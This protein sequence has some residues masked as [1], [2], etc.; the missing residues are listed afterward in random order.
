MPFITGQFTNSATTSTNPFQ[1][2]ERQDVGLTLKVTPQVNEGD[3]IKL[4]L[5][6]E[7]SSV[8]STSETSGPTTR[9]RSIKTSVLVDDGAILVLGGLIEESANDT[10]T[11]IPL[12]GDIPLLGKLFTSE[13]TSKSKQNLMVFLRPSILRD[14]N[15]AAIVTNEKYNYLRQLQQ[16]EKYDDGFGLLDEKPPVMP[17]LPALELRAEQEPEQEPEDDDGPVIYDWEG[18]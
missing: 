13:S 17:E 10:V 5:E 4:D 12:L 18:I 9:K 15:D 3:T 1:T 6:Q 14:F 7:T 16:D 2:I 8:A 11:K